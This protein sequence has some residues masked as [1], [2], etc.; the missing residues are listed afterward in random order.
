VLS[1]VPTSGIWPSSPPRMFGTISALTLASRTASYARALLP[2]ASL[3][4]WMSFDT[5]L[6]S[7]VLFAVS[8]TLEKTV[9]VPIPYL[10]R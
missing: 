7:A 9:P 8:S 6:S 4:F 10:L 5:S 1:M 2:S 3:H